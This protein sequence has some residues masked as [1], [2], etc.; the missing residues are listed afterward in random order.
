MALA[1][2]ALGLAIL[3]GSILA[4]YRLGWWAALLLLA[5]P[6]AAAG[7]GPEALSGPAFSI[8]AGVVAGVSFREGR[9]LQF[10]LLVV[11]ISTTAVFV[12]GYYFL[13]YAQNVDLV[14]LS[15]EAMEEAFRQSGLQGAEE[16]EMMEVALL[17]MQ[18]YGRSLFP[19]SSFIYALFMAFLVYAMV[20]V[21]FVKVP[22]SVQGPG[23]ERFRLHD[24]VIL[25]PIV[26][27]G[28]FL[29]V[30]SDSV[31]VIS[32]IGL[33]AGLIGLTLYFVQALGVIKSV[34]LR[35]GW[36]TYILPL[37]FFLLLLL[38]G[39]FT[40]FVIVM[41]AGVGTLDYWADFRK[42]D[43]VQGDEDIPG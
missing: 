31:P 11:T 6:L 7:T 30:D 5:L 12:G 34:L 17:W 35:R 28:V 20:A 42:L 3:A 15:V 26:G 1:G 33:N 25:L 4:G 43:K 16:K 23:I 38:G 41:L 18:K 40:F 27:W 21:W 10:Y 14:Q 13:L 37:G 36:P 9:S 19:F 32:M 2:I 22:S 24:V 8:I 29:L 39:P